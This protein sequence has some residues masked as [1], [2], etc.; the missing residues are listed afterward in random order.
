[1]LQLSTHSKWCYIYFLAD[2]YN[3]YRND[4]S[5]FFTGI[6]KDYHTPRDDA[7]LVNYEGLK[8]FQI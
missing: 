2:H 3:F 8:L 7:N 1:M 6:H 5:F 4:P